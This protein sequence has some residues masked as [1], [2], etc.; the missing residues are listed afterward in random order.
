MHRQRCCLR[1]F[2][3]MIEEN[4]YCCEEMKKHFNKELLMTKKDNEDFKNSTKFWICDN[5]YVDN[6]LKV[7]DQ[8]HIIRKDGGS[9]H[10][11]CNINLKFLSDDFKYLS[12]EIDNSVLNLIKQKGVYP[13]E[14]MRYFEKFKEGLPTKKIFI[15]PS[16]EEKLLPKNLN[17]FLKFGINVNKFFYF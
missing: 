13:N 3:N 2:S 10:R 17:M 5:T 14:Y 12:Q 6:D 8:C 11:D 1:F 15:A 16:P 7:R 9:A 4:K